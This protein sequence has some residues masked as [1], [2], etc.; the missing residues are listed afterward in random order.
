M[1][2]I[3]KIISLALSLCICL[4]IVGS[5]MNMSGVNLASAANP[6]A[7]LWLLDDVNYALVNGTRVKLGATEDCSPYQNDTGTMY[8]PVGILAEYMGA[9]YTYKD[10]DC[11][12]TTSSGDVSRLTVGSVSWTK[13]GEACEDFLIPVAAKGEMPFISILMAKEIFGFYHYYDSTMGLIIISKSSISGYSSSY[14]S[15]KSQIDT[16]SSMIMDRPSADTI[17]A[18]LE[19]YSGDTTHPRL[20]IDQNKFDQL[21]KIHTDSNEYGEYKTAIARWVVN[22]SN[23]FNKYFAISNTSG[24][25]MWKSEEARNLA[26]QPHFLYDENGNRLVGQTS[27]TYT[28]P[29]TG[30]EITVS[31]GE[32]SSRYGDGYDNGGRSSVQ[33]ITE[34]LRNIAFAWQITGEDKYVDAFYLLALDLDK[35]EHWG[36]GHFLNVADGAYAYAIGFD[37]IYHGFDDEPEKRKELADILYR[38]GL[39]M[40]YYSLKYENYS[41]R[42][43]SKVHISNEIGVSG[44]RTANRTNNWQTV[45]GSG[46]IVSALALAEYEEYRDNC[47]YV[48]SEYIRLVEKC[49]VQYAPDGAYPESPGY[50]G[51]GTNTLMNTIMALECSLGRSYGYKDIVGLHESYYFAA[52][53]CNSDY[54]IWGYHD[55]GQG[56]VDASYFYYAAKLF[57]DNNLAAFRNAMVFDA[58]IK[59]QLVDV[60]TYEPELDAGIHNMPLDNN[61][62]GIYTATFRSSWASGANFAGLHAGPTNQ[63]HGDFD[64]G[65][66]VLSMGGVDWCSD[67]GNEDYNVKGFWDT[68]NGGT[69]YRLYRKSLEG[70]SSIIIHSSQL[71]HGQKYV[72]ETGTF[73]KINSF[74]SDENGGYAITNMT[75][76]YGST[77]TEAYRGVLMTNSRRT[78]ILQDEISFNS[79]TTLTWVLN[80]AGT[81]RISE[82]GKTVTSVYWVDGEKKE[83][84][85]TMLTD[86]ESLTFRRLDNNETVLSNTITKENSGWSGACDTEQRI[87]IEAEGVQSFNVAVVFEIIT[88]PDEVVGYEKVPMSQ[89]TTCTDEWVNEANKDIVYP[90][91]KPVYKYTVSHFV[92]AN[93]QLREAYANKDWVTYAEIINKTSVYLTDY[94]HEDEYLGQYVY[95]YKNLVT[96]YNMEVEKINKMFEDQFFGIL[97]SA[98]PF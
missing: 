55:S 92:K 36:E 73:P 85:A 68:S 18:D 74:Y 25:V 93:N 53:I 62:K 90:E 27:Y 17:Y 60:L 86:D 10:G 94:D 5:T 59:M 22:G 11:E 50:W 89:W 42:D 38:R 30:E 82:D 71:V 9:T 44:F 41:E 87:V 51:Y 63:T 47:M 56:T 35:W 4:L 19:S 98:D 91:P 48:A 20:V 57:G 3:K 39:M 75:T 49:L 21:R 78:V 13:N 69:R 61:F 34:E 24:E 52:G 14:N 54:D 32:K 40:G 80:L 88:H 1:T 33:K 95:E 77:C 96:R 83:L 97:P 70:H 67:P 2:K 26:R 28:D 16:I 43:L 6:M 58:G 29:T 81:I 12:I 15:I 84:R 64:T 65:N 45:C 46:M 8:L 79:P 72:G 37:W 23:A 7:E 66:F 31:L 76:Q